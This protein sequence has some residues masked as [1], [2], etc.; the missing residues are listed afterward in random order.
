MRKRISNRARYNPTRTNYKLILFLFPETC[1]NFIPSVYPF[2]ILQFSVSRNESTE[3][4]VV[5]GDDAS[6]IN[7]L[8]MNRSRKNDRRTARVLRELRHLWLQIAYYLQR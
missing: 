7:H 5:T 2:V 3:L 8:S 1:S 6:F 4:S